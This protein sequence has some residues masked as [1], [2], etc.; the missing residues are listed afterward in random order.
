MREIKF[1]ARSK[2]GAWYY[3]DDEAYAL[4]EINGTLF[5]IEVENFYNNK[6][7]KE[8]V[9]GVALQCIGLKDKNLNDIYEEDRIVLDYPSSKGM[10]F[11]VKYVYAGFIMVDVQDENNHRFF[12][13]SK[14]RE[15]STEIVGDIYGTKDEQEQNEI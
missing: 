15:M 5:L 4:K 9:I 12:N 8:S 3:S 10:V 13:P 1:K 11:E 2:A 14:R 7:A 6:E